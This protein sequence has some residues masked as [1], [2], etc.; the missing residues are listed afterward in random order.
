M[1]TGV[2]AFIPEGHTMYK[3]KGSRMVNRNW[4]RP[5]YGH[6]QSMPE[7]RFSNIN[8][9]EPPLVGQR[10]EEKDD[11]HGVTKIKYKI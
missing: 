4:C 8:F 5:G 6:E 3:K 7:D 1:S 10:I 11:V 2:P 9:N